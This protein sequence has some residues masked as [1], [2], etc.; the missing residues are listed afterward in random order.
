ME[1]RRDLID[2]FRADRPTF[3]ARVDS[4]LTDTDRADTARRDALAA[5]PESERFDGPP[6][7]DDYGSLSLRTRDL[8]WRCYLLDHAPLGLTIC[9][10]AFRDTPI[11]YA[12][13]TMRAITGYSLADLR[14]EN[15]RLL[16]GPDTDADAVAD[17]REA[18]DIWEPVTV[19]L[20][21]YRKDGTRF[22]NRLSLVP[23]P[24]ETGTVGNWLGV[25]EAVDAVTETREQSPDG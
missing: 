10:P 19:E 4:V 17:L 13:R 22:R 20:W 8:V 23:L 24:D 2:L 6:E 15:P 11:V 25:Q 5:G 14:G 7:L 1:P 21:N 16:Q 3:R 12:T 18:V 9:G